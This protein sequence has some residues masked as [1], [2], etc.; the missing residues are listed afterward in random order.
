MTRRFTYQGKLRVL[1]RDIAPIACV[2]YNK[3]LFDAAK[4][5]YPKDDWTWG[6]LR[7]DALALTHRG[8]DAHAT[9]LGFADDWNLTDAWILAGGG[10]H[11]DDYSHPSRFSF[12]DKKALDGIFFRWSLLQ[13]DKVMPSSSENKTLGG[14]GMALFLNGELA[15]FHSGIWKTPTFRRI[16]AFDWDVAPFPHKAGAKPRYWSG[17]SGYAMRQ[18]VDNPDDCWQLIRYMAGPDGQ[19]RLAATGLAQPALR[20]LAQSPAFL[21][22]QKPH[23]KRMLLACAEAAQPSP[24]WEPWSAFQRTF[25]GP[26]TDAIWLK[27]YRGDP[28]ALLTGLQAQANAQYFPRP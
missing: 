12:A 20:A 17:G 5:P 22:G 21:D 7:R 27:G 23:N 28:K 4:L 14:G 9:Q 11:V 6:Q 24:A 10:G 26:K 16:T 8:P 19:R 1:P 18:D 15:M 3:S 2:Y 13:V 25:Y